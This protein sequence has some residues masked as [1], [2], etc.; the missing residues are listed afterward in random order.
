MNAADSIFQRALTKLLT[1]IFDGPPGQEAYLLNPGDPGLLRQLESIDADSAST[2]PM[3]GKTTIAAHVDHVHYGL[4]L[5]NRWAAGEANPWADAD[6]NASWTR[7]TVGNDQW[8]ALCASL[9][10]EA[11]TWQSH[12]AARSEWDDISAAG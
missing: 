7:T 9:R 6:W 1:E 12:A 4:A 10:R 8:R 5:L 11:E 3:P 2:R